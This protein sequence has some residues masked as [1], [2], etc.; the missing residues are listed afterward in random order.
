M[1]GKKNIEQLA[2][3]IIKYRYRYMCVRYKDTNRIYQKN[4][5]SSKNFLPPLVIILILFFFSSFRMR[6]T[7]TTI[8]KIWLSG[9]IDWL[10]DWL[11]SVQ[12]TF[13][14]RFDYKAHRYGTRF[15]VRSFVK[16]RIYRLFIY[17][18]I[19]IVGDLLRDCSIFALF[20]RNIK[21]VLQLENDVRLQF[22]VR[23]RLAWM[24]NIVAHNCGEEY[25]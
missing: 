4:Y 20:Q 17:I 10:I 21:A 18:F 3:I 23:L 16:V 14:L 19:Y 2:V 22:K 7:H 24:D 25:L 9:W 6:L 5:T 15:E 12:G 11:G 13:R 1:L 8:N